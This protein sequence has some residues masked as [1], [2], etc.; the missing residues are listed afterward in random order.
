MDDVIEDRLS[1]FEKVATFLT[2][3]SAALSATPIIGSSIKPGIDN[4]I[5]LIL[6][7]AGDAG[8]P[9]TGQTE[10]KHNLRNEVEA[11]GLALAG[12]GYAYFT[13]AVSDTAKRSYC[14]FNKSKLDTMRDN[15][16]YAD[17]KKMHQTVDPV[18]ALLAP[19]GFTAAMVDDYGTLL[20]DFLVEMQKPRDAIAARSASNK[21]LVRLMDNLSEILTEQL[22]P[23]MLYYSVNDAELY[24]Y[25]K[26]ARGID[27]SGG[28]AHP[29]EDTSITLSPY[30]YL[31]TDQTQEFTAN[32]RIVINHSSPGAAVLNI[33]FS[34]A[35]NS[36]GP[37]QRT[38]NPGETL[39]I[40]AGEIGFGV[41]NNWLNVYNTGSPVNASVTFRIRVYY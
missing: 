24:D 12:A 40:T 41:G 20:A 36:T 10:A 11:N 33:S 35:Q 30:Q 28:G 21:Q 22:D 39:D 1:M 15:D 9:T 19:Y 16:L 2:N 32:T 25:Y 31:S 17:L 7:E 38:I 29:D 5:S 6:T 27:Q 37:E 14:H 23:V 3:N 18:K 4:L 26:A 34:N 13:I 8:A